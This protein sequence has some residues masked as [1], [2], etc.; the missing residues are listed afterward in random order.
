VSR[1]RFDGSPNSSYNEFTCYT[2][3]SVLTRAWE[4]YVSNESGARASMQHDV[5][6]QLSYRRRQR[7]VKPAGAAPGSLL[8]MY[9]HMDDDETNLLA[10]R[11]GASNARPPPA[12]RL[13][14]SGWL[15]SWR[16]S[17]S[18][19]ESSESVCPGP[20]RPGLL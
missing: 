4:A 17:G 9:G 5:P 6:G 16:V 3:V 12:A 14:C 15:C 10:A 13:A 2:N 19:S 11:C 20:G 8:I 1:A 7:P 18:C